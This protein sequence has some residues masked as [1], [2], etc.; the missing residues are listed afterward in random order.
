M[1]M[2]SAI[3]LFS[4][5]QDSSTC[6][7]W[8][9]KKFAQVQTVGFDYGQ[10]HGAELEARR[11]ILEILGG[12]YGNLGADHL[13]STDIL[14]EIGG[15]SLLDNSAITTRE[16][17]L[18]ST[19][20]PG[21]NLFFLVC[22]AALAYRLGCGHIVTGVCETDFSGYPDCR[23]MSVKAANV[24]I[25]L[26][27]AS[28]M[29]IH[30]PLMWLTKAETWRLARRIGGDWL[31]E[32]IRLESHTCY[33]GDHSSPHEWGYGCGECPACLLRARGWREYAAGE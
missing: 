32:I 17:G 28:D 12:E 6:L 31:V 29:V 27:M 2:S 10:R 15:S 21:R 24:A 23:D 5:G 8:A 4:G 19:F 25:N 1:T 20:V 13:M 18:P 7:A 16:D 30:T 26:C 11:R 3:V 9:L 22:A 33:A 14:S